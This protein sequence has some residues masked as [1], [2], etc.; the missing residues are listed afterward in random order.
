[1][2]RRV[3]RGGSGDSD[4]GPAQAAFFSSPSPAGGADG[5]TPASFV[6]PHLRYCSSLQPG[7]KL[8]RGYD[9]TMQRQVVASPRGAGDLSPT[10]GGGAASVSD[11]LA[12]PSGRGWVVH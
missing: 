7:D 12:S 2:H 10:A 6:L 3:R 9:L 5:E 8:I 4:T 11:S 1:M